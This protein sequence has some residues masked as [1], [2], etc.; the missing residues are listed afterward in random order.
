MLVE[1]LAPGNQVED[2]SCSSLKLGS[3]W[4]PLFLGTPLC[5]QGRARRSCDTNLPEGLLNT[6]LEVAVM[7]GN[8]EAV[9]MFLARNIDPNKTGSCK[10]HQ[11]INGNAL[12]QACMTGY[13]SIVDFLLQPLLLGQGE[14]PGI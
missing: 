2:R 6:G 8:F 11:S 1:L 7:K 5:D 4:Q 10:G 14:W 9:G 12:R 3:P 13:E